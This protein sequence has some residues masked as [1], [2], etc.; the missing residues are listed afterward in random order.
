M[1]R[2]CLVDRRMEIKVWPVWRELYIQPEL[3]VIY[4][5]GSESIKNSHITQK[6]RFHGQAINTVI[7]GPIIIRV[8]P[9]VLCSAVAILKF[10]KTSEQETQ[11]F[12]F[13]PRAESW[14]VSFKRVIK[15]IKVGIF[16]NCLSCKRWELPSMC[17]M[18]HQ[19]MKGRPTEICITLIKKDNTF[20]H[21]LA[22]I[23]LIWK[24]TPL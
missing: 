19:E 8:S 18:N 11:N 5:A 4:I 17:I 7:K 14:F 21:L 6:G 20:L 22:R 13:A 16:S 9:F 3:T 10:S 24:I 1:S 23:Y 2:T 12:H 15:G